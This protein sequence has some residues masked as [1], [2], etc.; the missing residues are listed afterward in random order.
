[1]LVNWPVQWV[2]G[3]G[4]VSEERLALAAG[5]HVEGWTRLGGGLRG[6][7]A[8]LGSGCTSGGFPCRLSRSS[9]LAL[10]L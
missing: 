1:M 8:E 3:R 4:R 2:P 7:S 10:E 6:F 5:L 9:A